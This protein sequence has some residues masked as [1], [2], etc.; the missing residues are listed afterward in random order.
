MTRIIDFTEGAQLMSRNDEYAIYI[1]YKGD[2][3]SSRPMRLLAACAPERTI[4]K[5]L[6]SFI[7]KLLNNG[8]RPRSRARD[9]R[10]QNQ[11]SLQ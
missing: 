1:V 7:S 5:A 10:T 6:P 11:L 3:N 2:E 8:A 9:L 4:A